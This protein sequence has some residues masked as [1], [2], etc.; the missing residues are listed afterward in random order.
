MEWQWWA[1]AVVIYFFM[2]CIGV[3]I[4]V[5][6]Y[7]SHKSFQTTPKFK[8]FFA[9]CMT[10]STIGS[11][12][13]WL[14]MHR[15]HHQ[16]SDTEKDPHTPIRENQSRF[17]SFVYAYFGLWNRYTAELKYIRD[18]RKQDMHKFFHFY[19]FLVILSYVLVL[20]LVSWKAAL[21]LYCVPAVFCFHAASLIVSAGHTWGAV[22]HDTKDQS[23]NN[24]LV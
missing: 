6:R 5:H 20:G 9:F 17:M 7:F 23:R 16:F 22:E 3:D 24:L 11:P 15:M 1:G 8:W 10:L 19:Y 12:L 14:G 2:F 4:G 21:F 18:A 13:A